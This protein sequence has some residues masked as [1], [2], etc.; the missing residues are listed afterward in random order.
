MSEYRAPLSDA[1]FVLHRVFNA[2]Q[3]WAQLPGCGDWSEELADAVLKEVA[4]IST[5][6]LAPINRSGDV[7]GITLRDGEVR[8]PRGFVEAYRAVRENGWLGF[9]GSPE[10]G[11]QGAPHMLD[12]LT[13]EIF[14][15]ANTSFSLYTG[16]TIGAAHAIAAHAE[17]SLKARCLPQLYSG[18]WA[19]CMCLTEAHAGTDL[20]IIRTRAEEDGAGGYRL[21]GTKIFT[22]AGE[23]DLSENI[24]YLVLARLPD[25]PPGSRG[26]S[27]FLVPK[28]L[29]DDS[30][31]CGERN[32]VRCLSVEDKM[33]IHASSTCVMQFDAAAGFIIGE[34][35]RGL[36][37]MFT[38][39][40]QERLF[41]GLQGL[42][43]SEGA[44]QKARDYA[45]ERIQGRSAAGPAAPDQEADPIIV[46]PDVRRM[47]L[48]QKAL[49]EGGR[50]FGVYVGMQ[51][52][53]SKRAEGAAQK[54]AEALVALLTPVAKAFLAD[55]GFEGCVLAQQ[56]LG[57]HGY[58]R[59]W[60]LEQRVR[61]A[62]ITQIY[63]GTNGIQALDLMGRKVVRDGGRSLEIFLRE[64]RAFL[65][66]EGTGQEMQPYAEPLA[67][68]L[69]LLE[70]TTAWVIEN[71]AGDPA[72]VGAASVEYLDLL[73]YTAYAY[74]WAR[75]AKAAL[76]EVGGDTAGFCRSKLQ[77]AD[78]F[79]SR[80]LP[81][82][83]GLAASIRAGSASLMALDAADF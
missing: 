23:H 19:G 27:L 33:G 69:S 8:T 78:F 48:T 18:V 29:F 38:M 77:T 70:D 41:V 61:D 4:K 75:M 57:G 3:L 79:M 6:L 42:A 65:D 54:D 67:A 10:Y 28:F 72:A 7:E 53:L 46:H 44:Y 73:G 64:I 32:G 68:A 25:A 45:L 49:I 24:L 51:L 5:E 13:N 20:G 35:H 83:A 59:E 1:Q 71:A 39:M 11:G 52:D 66:T 16:L 47:L 37:A 26:I 17:E 43:C 58:I 36:A 50:A 82:T 21:S 63:E 9:L 40:N 30:G 12:V 34:P 81:R 55:R 60:G 22:T 62:R 31:A 56:V 76:E 14:S 74:L 2:P 15:A 80:L